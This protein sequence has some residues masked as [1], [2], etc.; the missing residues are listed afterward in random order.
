MIKEGDVFFVMTHNSWLSRTIA[1][2]MQSKWSHSG[3]VYDVSGREP[4]TFETTNTETTLQFLN[5]YI[6]N[7][8]IT[9]EIW[10]PIDAT[11][12]QRLSICA[13]AKLTNEMIYGYLQLLSLGLRR[14]LMRFG[15]KSDNLIRQGQVCCHVVY[16]GYAGK[17]FGPI[18][19][20]DTE[21][22]D[23]QEL[24]EDVTLSGKFKKVYG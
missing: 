4:Y 17:G 22:K 2:F 10:S 23:T 15:V 24:Y 1:W 5:D 11:D 9:L 20:G 6:D 16:K 21:A 18:S 14:L 19:E 8:N 12:E 3:L 13:D 7:P